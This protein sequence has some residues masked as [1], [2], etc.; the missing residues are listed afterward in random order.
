MNVRS[1][2]EMFPPVN[3]FFS[4]MKC[5]SPLSLI[6]QEA[7][8]RTPTHPSRTLLSKQSDESFADERS[9]ESKKGRTSYMRLSSGVYKFY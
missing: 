8:D 3:H 7:E 6:Q 5:A 4:S 9:L 1:D 2:E